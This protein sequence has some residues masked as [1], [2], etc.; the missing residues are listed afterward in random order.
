M[1]RRVISTNIVLRLLISDLRK[2][3]NQYKAPVWDAVAELL[4]KSSRKRPVVNLSKISRYSSDGDTIVVPGKVLGSGTLSKRVT[5]AAFS[6]SET[7]L[8]KIKA[9]GGRGIT[10]RDL[11][12]ENPEGRG[13]KIII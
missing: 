8:N 4:S 13:V 7:A 10:I 2:Y 1:V 12:K 3:A 9:G 6:F 5:I 11:L